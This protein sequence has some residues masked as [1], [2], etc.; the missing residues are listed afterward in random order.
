MHKG[1][2]INEFSLAQFVIS[3][4][5]ALLEQIRER[6]LHSIYLLMFLHVH[7]TIAGV[8]L[9]V[10]GFL[11]LL[12]NGFILY[13]IVVGRI[14]GRSFGRIWIS[15]AAAHCLESV[16][17]IVFIGPVTLIDPIIF[18]TLLAQRIL[19]S[20]V[21]FKAPVWIS[22]L[23]IAVDRAVMVS[24]PFKY[25]IYF[26]HKRTLCLIIWSWIFAI[27]VA[28]P[29]VIDPCQQTPL[30]SSV[31]FYADRPD[32]SLAIH[33]FAI[34]VPMALFVGT[35]IAD[36]VALYKLY[37]LPCTRK[38]LDRGVY[39]P[40]RAKELRLCYMIL[41]E[42]VVLGLLTLFI[43]LGFLFE[44]HLLNFLSTTFLWAMASAVD[45]AIV[46]IFNTE[47]RTLRANQQH[48][49]ETI[50]SLQSKNHV[51]SSI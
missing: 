29:N 2:P 5:D 34:V 17:F 22:N 11:G 12:I 30:N 26:S 48:K 44:N 33:L 49:V 19:H 39:S 1:P 25:K 16:M 32:C 37:T 28:I 35:A 36:A 31:S 8:L 6:D 20:I 7:N 41:T 38:E 47:M 14:F 21:L 10:S 40:N 45:G 51:P 23:L 46:L 42:V 50:S 9:E 13:K 18:D 3:I 43:K 24:L 27:G 15:R 4:R